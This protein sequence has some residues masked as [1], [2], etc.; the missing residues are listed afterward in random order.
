MSPQKCGRNALHKVASH[1]RLLKSSATQHGQECMNQSRQALS[2]TWRD[3]TSQG[4]GCGTKAMTALRGPHGGTPR[5]TLRAECHMARRAWHSAAEEGG[6]APG[7]L[8]CRG[9]AGRRAHRRAWP[10]RPGAGTQGPALQAPWTPCARTRSP[11]TL[12]NL[13]WRQASTQ[14]TAETLSAPLE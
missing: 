1:G 2:P 3:K 7:R 11:D 6:Q 5:G 10:R 4:W 13:P 8:R 14:R 12:P 9:A